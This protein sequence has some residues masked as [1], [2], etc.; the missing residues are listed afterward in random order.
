MQIDKQVMDPDKKTLL[1]NVRLKAEDHPT[2]KLLLKVTNH[3]KYNDFN[4]LRLAT[5][6]GM[7]EGR[8]SQ[9]TIPYSDTKM[10]IFEVNVCIFTCVGNIF[11]V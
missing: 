4:L 6:V 2:E 11:C 1:K 7:P 3:V 5:D 9:K 8:F 10:K